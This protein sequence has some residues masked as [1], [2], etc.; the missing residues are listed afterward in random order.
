L[1]MADG[2]RH[3]RNHA[4]IR[5]RMAYSRVIRR[6]IQRRRNQCPFS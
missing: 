3:L 1:R 2:A 5:L 4:G 6:L